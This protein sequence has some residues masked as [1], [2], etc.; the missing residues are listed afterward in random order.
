MNAPNEKMIHLQALRPAPVPS[1]VELTVDLA[2]E[3]VRSYVAEGDEFQGDLHC[4]GGVRIAGRVSGSVHC[5]SGTVV[6]EKTA[7]VDGSVTGGDKVLIDGLV[8][9]PNTQ[10]PIKVFCP[11]L[12]ALFNHAVVHADIEYGKLATYDDMTHNGHSRKLQ[13]G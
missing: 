11:G 7:Q 13:A 10:L 8:G 9:T 12:V 6:I 3:N 1:A 4:Q 5:G 2:Q